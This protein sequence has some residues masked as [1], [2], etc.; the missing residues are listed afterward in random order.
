MVFKNNGRKKRK[1]T[2]RGV[3]KKN[4]SLSEQSYSI[5]QKFPQFNKIYKKDKVIWIGNI[6]PHPLCYT[7]T[8]KIEYRLTGY[9]KVWVLYPEL[10]SYQNKP[11]PHMY[12]QKRLCLFYP[13]AN[14]WKRSMWISQTIIPWTSLWLYYYEY[15]L[16][17]GEWLGGGIDHY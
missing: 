9:P 8:I 3:I 2:K 7:Y 12:G 11:I 16:I 1:I 17:T 6:Q 4:L 5:Q 10:R 14:E 13:K 15:W